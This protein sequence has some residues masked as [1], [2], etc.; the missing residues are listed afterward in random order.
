MISL[1]IYSASAAEA[2][3]L[4]LCQHARLVDSIDVS[5]LP[6]SAEDL[7]AFADVFPELS[8][9]VHILSPH[10]GARRNSAQWYCHVASKAYPRNSFYEVMPGIYVAAPYLSFAERA[11][12]LPWEQ[13]AMLGME[14]CGRYSTLALH[15]ARG[16]ID[17]SRGF[18]VRSA[19]TTPQQ[20]LRYS[21]ALGLGPKSSAV[22][23]SKVIA[24]MMRSPMEAALYLLFTLRPLR[25]GYHLGGWDANHRIVL[26]EHL[27]VVAGVEGYELDLYRADARL[28]LEYDGSKY[29]SDENQRS[30]DN[31]RK[32]LLG[33]L[34]IRVLS[35]DK[36]QLYCLPKIDGV[37]D[38]V[39]EL[40]GEEKVRCDPRSMA[41]R[42]RLRRLIL[43]T[44]VD[45]YGCR[46]HGGLPR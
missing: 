20:L 34:G 43:D 24:G 9:P 22:K 21:E 32:T 36:S 13:A 27:A 18:F 26:P 19:L 28:S 6:A 29:H 16:R 14:L 12:Q 46:G 31:L 41:A 25:G 4:G 45:L 35:V 37:A 15:G 44:G 5:T 38:A 1:V 30:Y 7:T 40:L 3:D 33:Q 2:V 8:R 10:A 23:A 11:A 17:P 39:A 42:K